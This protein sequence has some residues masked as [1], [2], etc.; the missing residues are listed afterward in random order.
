MP[1]H[2]AGGPEELTL[3]EVDVYR[4]RLIEDHKKAKAASRQQTRKRKRR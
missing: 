1:W 3:G 2:I 4:R